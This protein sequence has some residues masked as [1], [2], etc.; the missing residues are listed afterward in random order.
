MADNTAIKTKDNFIS[1]NKIYQKIAYYPGCSLNST[2]VDLNVS[3]R[4]LFDVIG[5]TLKE[6]EDWNCCGTTP[7]G[8]VSQEMPNLLSARNLL[9][10]K[11]M[12]YD[13]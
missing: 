4:K 1:G 9:L 11:R 6:I 7:A 8:N 3:V 10:A 5:V 2:A 12:G 13:E